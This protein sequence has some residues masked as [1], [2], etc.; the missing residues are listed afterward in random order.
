MSAHTPQ[1]LPH[2]A[3]MLH[4]SNVKLAAILTILVVVALLGVYYKTTWSMI[5]IWERS[6]T[7]AHGFLIFPFSAYLVWGQRQYLSTFSPP[8][9]GRGSS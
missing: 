8:A 1:E 3:V 7:F 2:H 9:A 5:E 4:Q 6:D